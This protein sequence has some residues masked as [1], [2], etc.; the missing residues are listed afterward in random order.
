MI[1]LAAPVPIPGHWVLRVMER[2]QPSGATKWAE[3]YQETSE[4]IAEASNADPLFEGPDGPMRTASI[5]LAI[6]LFE[7]KFNPRAIDAP[8]HAFGI[9]QIEARTVPELTVNV[10]L[11]PREASPVAIRLIR[12]SLKVCGN[13]GWSHKLSWY[14]SGGNGCRTQGNR[15]SAQR[16]FLADK[17]LRDYPL[18][19]F[20]LLEGEK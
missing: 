15:T 6:G 16:M 10:L 9:Y 18:E 7:S 20:P 3:T 14:T 1:T 19:M 17:I 12:T 11:V 2:L 5:L 13:V 8:Q 4:A